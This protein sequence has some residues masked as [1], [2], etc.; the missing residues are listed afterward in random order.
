[1]SIDPKQAPDERID[2]GPHDRPTTLPEEPVADV[3][4]LGLSGHQGLWVLA[5]D[6]EFRL[7]QVLQEIFPFVLERIFIRRGGQLF[8]D[9]ERR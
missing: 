9:A 7:L 1:M 4:E 3:A 6:G 5:G 2:P 8:V